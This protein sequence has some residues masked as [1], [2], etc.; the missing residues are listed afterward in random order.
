MRP[1]AYGMVCRSPGRMLR[2]ISC[3]REFKIVERTSL[4]QAA[5]APVACHGWASHAREGTKSRKRYSGKPSSLSRAS[6]SSATSRWTISRIG[7]AALLPNIREFSPSNTKHGM[8]EP[9]SRSRAIRI[10]VGSM[11]ASTSTSSDS[12]KVAPVSFGSL[13]MDS[14][15]AFGARA[16]RLLHLGCGI[17]AANPIVQN[18]PG[19]DYEQRCDHRVEAMEI[20]AERFPILSELHSDVGQRQA[21]WI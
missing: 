11:L 8:P 20:G 6:A 5:G 3:A 7:I 17:D 21:P 10:W 18:Q 14:I 19:A 13:A 15:L 12:S 2:G 9:S 4:V 16:A 1:W